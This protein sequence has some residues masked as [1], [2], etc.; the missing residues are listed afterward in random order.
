MLMHELNHRMK[1]T[2]AVVQAIASQS[3]R[4]ATSMEEAS[5]SLSARLAAYSKAHDILLQRDW[6]GTTMAAI[7]EGTATSL[8]LDSTQRFRMQGPLLEL[9]PQAALSF[10]LVLHELATNASKYGALSADEGKV[11]VTWSIFTEKGGRRFRF[12]WEE[13]GGPQVEQPTRKGFGSKLLA[14]SLK[15]FGI[16]VVEFRAQGVCVEVTGDLETLQ[17]RT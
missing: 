8:A 9:G 3:F 17:N 4:N 10:A 13:N 7:V 14:T 16:A 11:D 2:L 1:N 6:R 5:V 15:A 12:S